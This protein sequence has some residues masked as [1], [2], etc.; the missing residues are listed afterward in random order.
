[1]PIKIRHVKKLL[2]QYDWLHS[3][4][5]KNKENIDTCYNLPCFCFIP[6]A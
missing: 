5:L 6:Y 4:F 3:M 2:K 1:M